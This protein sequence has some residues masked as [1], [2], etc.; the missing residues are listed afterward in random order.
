MCQTNAVEEIKQI[1]CS[2]TFF[3]ENHAVYD[4]MWKNIV[5]WGRPQMLYGTCTLHAG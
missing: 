5:E 2:I 4:I 1:L 3:F